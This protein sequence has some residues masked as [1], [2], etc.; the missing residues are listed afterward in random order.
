MKENEF[1]I[2]Y[3]NE[4]LFLILKIEQRK[5]IIEIPIKL[6]KKEIGINDNIEEIMIV[7]KENQ[8]LK[9]EFNIFREKCWG[10]I[11]ILQSKISKLEKE[12]GELKE[13]INN[14]SILF[15]ENQKNTEDNSKK[16]LS[17]FK[18]IQNYYSR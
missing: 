3:E 12:N 17:L 15:Q 7:L 14:I 4:E 5:K 16:Y 6:E 2:K 11:E 10:E 9:K 18:E 1:N 13:K 8:N